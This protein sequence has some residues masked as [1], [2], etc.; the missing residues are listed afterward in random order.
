MKGTLLSMLKF[1]DYWLDRVTMYKLLLYYLIAL[2]L[3]AIGL[4]AI[5]VLNFNP[6][7]VG[8]SAAFIT[9]VCWLANQLFGYVFEVATNRES[10]YLTALILALIITPTPSA[11][12]ALFLAMA[13]IVAM[14]SKYILAIGKNHVF[15]PA[16]I[17]VVLTSFAAHQSASWWIGSSQMLPYVV[18][19]GLLIARKIQRGGMVLVFLGSAAL[20]TIVI[21]LFKHANTIDILQKTALHSSL[22]FLAFVMLTEPITS[23]PTKTKQFWYAS[24]VGLLFP[25]QISIFKIYS[26]PELTLSIGNIY[27]Y[28][29]SPK[30]KLLPKLSKKERTGPDTVDFVFP[31]KKPIS[32]EPGQYMEWTLAHNRSDLRGNRRFFTLASSPTENELRV[33]VKFYKNGSSFKKAMLDM[34]GSTKLVASQLSGDF[35]LPQDPSHKLAFIAGGIGITPYRSMIKYLLDK[36][37]QRDIALIYSEKSTSSLAYQEL[38]KEASK[39]LGAKIV[40]TLTDKT[41]VP[42]GWSNPTGKISEQ[43]IKTQIADYTERLFY[44]SGPQA[45]VHDT[46]AMLKNIGVPGRHIKTDFFS[47]YA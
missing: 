35:T 6:V 37:E 33:G 26:T 4:S 17:A 25:P 40:Y 15:N 38:F 2:V 12:N 3:I 46:K 42:A 31:L 13:G 21:N 23:P 30:L 8:M 36:N 24:I 1:V 5:N 20:S 22:F 10:A 34:N 28:I 16:A 47:G 32:F 19:G 45:M 14:A 11:H 7:A 27:S 29:V 43:M 39:R 9:A 44:I 18:I 41:S